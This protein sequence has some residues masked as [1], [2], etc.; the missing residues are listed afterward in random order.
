[1]KLL[2]VFS[3]GPETQWSLEGLRAGV[4]GFGTVLA[5]VSADTLL[6]WCWVVFVVIQIVAVMPKAR[7]ALRQ[8][9]GRK[10]CEPKD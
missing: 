9:F 1:M 3:G 5:G 2:D 8:L 7:D 6:T 10:D 4:V